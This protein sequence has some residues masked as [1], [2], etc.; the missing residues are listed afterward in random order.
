M[1][2]NCTSHKISCL[3]K[4]QGARFIH[5]HGNS[6]EQ[7]EEKNTANSALQ[8]ECDSSHFGLSLV[9][10]GTHMV[11]ESVYF[12][13][14]CLTGLSIGSMDAMCN[15]NTHNAKTEELTVTLEHR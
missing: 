10:L 14:I 2:G 5:S 8:V 12:G 13:F 6:F 1:G 7:H 9:N 11:F 15:R 3:E 4:A